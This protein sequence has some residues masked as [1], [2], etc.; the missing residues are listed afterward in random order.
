MA[1]ASQASILGY[2]LTMQLHT[3]F[4]H[5]S[6][7]EN[8]FNAEEARDDPVFA[9]LVDGATAHPDFEKILGE[10]SRPRPAVVFGEKGSGKTAL[11]LMIERHLDMYNERA[12]DAKA[13]V[14]RYD[15]MNPILDRL[16]RHRGFV[17]SDAALNRLSLSDHIDAM[18]AQGVTDLVTMILQSPRGEHTPI[19]I[20]RRLP[21]QRRLEL[22]TLALIYDQPADGDRAGRWAR[23]RKSL[24]LHAF[25]GALFMPWLGVL[26]A[27]SAVG[28]Y[29]GMRISNIQ[30]MSL[31]VIN[32][33]LAA[34]AVLLLAGGAWR[35]LGAWGKAR[36]IRR[37]LRVLEH[38]PDQL[39]KAVAGMPQSDLAG[40]PLPQRDD[41]DARYQLMQRFIE[42]IEHFGY[43]SLVVLVD[44]IDEPDAVQGDPA[45]M[46]L[47]IWPMFDNK[48]LQQDHV[49]VKLLL[50][51]EL[52]HLL[53]KE[54]ADFFQRARLDK[55]HMVDRLAWSG[56]LLYDLCSR[57]LSACRPSGSEPLTLADLFAD[58]VDRQMLIDAL[59]QMRQPRDAFKFLYQVIQEHCGNV[60]EESP[61]WKIPRLTLEQARREQ[62]RRLQE[63]E[64][65]LSP[66]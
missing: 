32:G 26:S 27:L 57:R 41:L 3:F 21:R 48:F 13:W 47:L 50:P 64:R 55:Q 38:Q 66:G 15:D 59:D 2:H 16:M 29:F 37:E 11:R 49:G 34:A 14:I 28:L 65:G 8:P 10:P 1:L 9:R 7:D 46:R 4:K 53:R 33:A 23:L 22:A 6:I 52:R 43:R 39:R 36:R 61:D 40:Q 58:D 54:D 45:R 51:M 25:P 42:T 63:F 56:A 18:L 19:R 31:T 12:G 44:R 62:S 5:W 30:D 24:R 20:A 35:W 17:N 60:T